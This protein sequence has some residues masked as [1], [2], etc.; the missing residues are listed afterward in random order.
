MNFLPPIRRRISGE[1][2][3]YEGLCA[4]DCLRG[5][6]PPTAC[7]TVSVPLTTPTV[8]DFSPPACVAGEVLS[9]AS[10]VLALNHQFSQPGATVSDGDEVAFLPPVSGG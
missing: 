6:C 1:D 4:F 5:Y 10:T 8:S 7:N 2:A 9:S 3:S